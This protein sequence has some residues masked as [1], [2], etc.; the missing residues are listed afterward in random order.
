MHVR[1]AL[2]ALAITAAIVG[3]AFY[4]FGSDSSATS[5]PTD[6]AGPVCEWCRPGN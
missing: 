5:T 2:A 4:G 6:I 1:R 3:G